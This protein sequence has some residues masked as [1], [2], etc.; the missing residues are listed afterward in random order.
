MY[1]HLPI[2]HTKKS[3][4]PG[5]SLHQLI[6]VVFLMNTLSAKLPELGIITQ[7]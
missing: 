2:P 5:E 1:K 4:V 6:P 7:A 3:V